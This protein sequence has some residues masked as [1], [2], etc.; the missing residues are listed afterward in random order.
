MKIIRG[1]KSHHNVQIIFTICGNI[2]V[3]NFDANDYI[4]LKPNSELGF[5]ELVLKKGL[6][7]TKKVLELIL[8]MVFTLHNNQSK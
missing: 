7:F 1:H 2:Y 8:L 6:D 3:I 4:V 5:L